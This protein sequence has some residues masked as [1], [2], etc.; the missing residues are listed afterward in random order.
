MNKTEVINNLNIA[1]NSFFSKHNFKPY[2]YDSEIGWIQK[3]ENDLLFID[4]NYIGLI[5][6]DTGRRES[7]NI[8]PIITISNNEI[9]KHYKNITNNS[10]LKD[11][12]EFRTVCVKVAVLE[13]CKDGFFTGPHYNYVWEINYQSDVAKISSLLIDKIENV[14]LPNYEKLKT[15]EQIDK[16][17]NDINTLDKSLIYLFGIPP[18]AIKGIIAAKLVDNKNVSLLIDYYSKDV[19]K[20]NEM[21]QKEFHNLKEYL[22]TF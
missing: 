18:R 6:P 15:V 3:N 8:N 13:N 19:L 17:Y 4:F 2:K 10:Y 21:Y 22:K 14:V 7:Y 12:I 5:H 9:E 1:V 11:P 16:L 20:W